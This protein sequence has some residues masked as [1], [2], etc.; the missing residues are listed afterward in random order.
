MASIERTAYPRFRRLVTARELAGLSPT[1]DE[2]AWAR[3][4][5]RTATHR[6][7]PREGL[8][9]VWPRRVRLS[10]QWGAAATFSHSDAVGDNLLPLLGL[11]V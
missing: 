2:L 3:E 8:L 11:S 7:S 9:R 4:R 5:T 6:T 10:S 1:E